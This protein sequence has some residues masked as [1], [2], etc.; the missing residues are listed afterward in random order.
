MRLHHWRTREG[1]RGVRAFAT[2]YRH[3]RMIA[4]ARFEGYIASGARHTGL[5]LRWDE[6]HCGPQVFAGLGHLACFWLTVGSWPLAKRLA[7]DRTRAFRDWDIVDVSFH[8]RAVWW[9]IWHDRDSWSSKT[10]RWRKGSFHWWRFL[11]GKP[12]HS[13]EIVDEREVGIPMPEGVYRAAVKIERRRWK[14]PRW[15]WAKSLYTYDV[16]VLSRPSPSGPYVPEGDGPRTS[17]YIP[18]PGKGE[19]AWDCGPDG[20]F[21]SSGPGRTVEEAVGHVVASALRDRKRHGGRHDYA[22]PITPETA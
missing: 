9:S 19:N 11:V 8:G 3:D 12:V 5:G 1:T 16:D 18:V 21:G 13:S 17:G 4:E 15:P 2:L 10:P 6:E 14:A 22:E 7:G 20:I